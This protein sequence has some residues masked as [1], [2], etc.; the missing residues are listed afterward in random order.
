MLKIGAHV[1]ASGGAHKIFQRGKELDCECLQL[2]TRAPS[3]WKAKPLT[4]EQIAL[5]RSER[6]AHGSIPVIA[7]DIYLNNLAAEDDKIR[8]RSI[9]TMVE[10]IGRCYQ[11]GVDGLVCHLGSHKGGAK[12]GIRRYASAIKT[13]LKRTENTPTPI[14][15]E[16]CA[17]Q[18]NCLGHELDH[19]SQVI[20]RN[21][22]HPRLGVCVDTCHIFVAGYDLRDR[23]SYELFWNLFDESI[24]LD[25]LQ[26]FHLNDSKKPLGSRVDRHDHIAKGEIGEA[27][28]QF[29]LQDRRFKGLPAVIETPESKTMAQTNIDRLKAFRGKVQ[30]PHTTK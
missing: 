6:K 12:P 23:D 24:G 22:S 20:L 15:L 8:K 1:S 29:L 11:L 14:L 25:R 7:H 3:Q 17:G 9:K 21:D 5:F 27:A 10:E 26:A 19:L 18:G 4:E 13:I 30:H 2:F 28:F 16:T